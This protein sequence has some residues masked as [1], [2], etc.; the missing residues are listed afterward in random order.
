[1]LLTDIL[2]SFFDIFL[3]SYRQRQLTRRFNLHFRLSTTDDVITHLHIL[4]TTY[5]LMTCYLDIPV[6]KPS[7]E[8]TNKLMPTRTGILLPIPLPHSTHFPLGR[9][10]PVTFLNLPRP[11]LSLVFPFSHLLPRPV[12]YLLCYLTILPSHG[13]IGDA[14]CSPRLG[15]STTET[16]CRRESIGLRTQPMASWTWNYSIRSYFLSPFFRLR[17]GVCC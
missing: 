15:R 2:F 14:T 16:K 13:P 5:N 1:M 12:S 7:H 10:M 4:P 17:T 3:L 6:Y 11:D 8:H 9:N